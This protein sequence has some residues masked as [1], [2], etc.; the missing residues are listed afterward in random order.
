MSEYCDIQYSNI[1]FDTAYGESLQ[2][3]FLQSAN[4]CDASALSCEKIP[5]TEQTSSESIKSD[6]IGLE[7]QIGITGRGGKRNSLFTM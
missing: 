3:F 6:V 5:F 4:L 7:R 1:Y 2:R